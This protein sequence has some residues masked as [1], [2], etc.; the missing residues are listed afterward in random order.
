MLIPEG[1]EVESLPQSAIVQLKDA[2][3]EFKYL[4][5][6]MNNV[7]RIES[8]VNLAQTIF[9]ATDYEYIQKFYDNIIKKQNKKKISKEII[10]FISERIN[11]QNN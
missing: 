7:I 11:E 4:V 8:E 6:H 5:K 1:Y 3:G 9:A 2:A 10:E